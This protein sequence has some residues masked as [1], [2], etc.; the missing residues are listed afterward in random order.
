MTVMPRVRLGAALLTACVAGSAAG[1][2]RGESGA[3]DVASVFF[4]AK[5]ENRNQVHYGIHVDAACVPAGGAPVFAYWRMLEHGPRATEP[6]L[7]REVPAY[8]LSEQRVIEKRPDGGRTLLQLRAL[9]D[10]IIEIDTTSRDG[11]CVATATTSI[12]GVP[13]VLSNVFAQLRW[14]FGVDYLLIA[15]RATLDGRVVRERV[16]R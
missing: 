16:A 5:S 12:G 8:G 6:L 11:A 10:R 7:D 14:P 4:V 1:V 9:G 3:R 15:G 2:A 13:A